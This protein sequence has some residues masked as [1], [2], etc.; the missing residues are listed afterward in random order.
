MQL[1]PKKKNLDEL[2][3]SHQK[4]LLIEVPILIYVIL[5]WKT[6]PIHH[7]LCNIILAFGQQPCWDSDWVEGPQGVI[8]R[9]VP[10]LKWVNN[11]SCQLPIYKAIYRGYNSIYDC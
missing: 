4:P 3:D 6:S 11:P 2:Q 5:H 1:L 10:P 9:V 8:S 7:E